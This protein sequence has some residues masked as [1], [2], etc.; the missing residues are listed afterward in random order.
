VIVALEQLLDAGSLELGLVLEHLLGVGIFPL[1][2]S[3]LL[4]EVVFVFW[5]YEGRPHALLT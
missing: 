5:R 4:V 2:V 1:T 3:V